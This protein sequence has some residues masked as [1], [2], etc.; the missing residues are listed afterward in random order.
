MKKP[1]IRL[2]QAHLNILET[3]PPQFQRIYL[4]QLGSLFDSQQQDR[5]SWGSRFHLLMQQA[6]LGLPIASLA[7]QDEQMQHSIAA[8]RMAAAEIW[9]ADGEIWREAEHYRTLMFR[10]YLLSVVYDLLILDGTQARIFDWKTYLKP[11]NPTKLA[12]NWQTRLYLYVLA[13]TSAYSPEQ[14]SMTY[15]F[16]Q[17]PSEPQSVTFTYNCQKHEANR[18][19]LTQLLDELDNYLADYLSH[20]SSFPHRSRCQE[21]C[22][23][24]ESISAIDERL[25]QKDRVGQKQGLTDIDAIAEIALE[26]E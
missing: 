1:L 7:I 23:Y 2:S 10:E 20:K 18:R 15:W 8:L 12:K 9:Q 4:E 5:Q 16:V 26:T 21:S 13:E 14:I 24:Y 22:P 3:C 25:W 6:E 11:K 19:D 17:L